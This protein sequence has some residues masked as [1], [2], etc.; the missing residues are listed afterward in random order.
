M[1]LAFS[2][3]KPGLGRTIGVGD[4]VYIGTVCIGVAERVESNDIGVR[5][6]VRL[7]SWAERYDFQGA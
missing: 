3:A 7:H 1:T 4:N 5:V 6:V 2:L